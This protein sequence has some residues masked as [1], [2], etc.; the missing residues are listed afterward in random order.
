MGGWLSVDLLGIQLLRPP[1]PCHGPC[2]PGVRLSSCAT[3]AAPFLCGP[4]ARLEAL[5][6]A[7]AT[8]AAPPSSFSYSPCRGAAMA[9]SYPSSPLGASG[10]VTPRAAAAAGRTASVGTRGPMRASA[11]IT[12][13]LASPAASRYGKPPAMVPEWAAVPHPAELA[14]SLA[15]GAPA[16]PRRVA[17]CTHEERCSAG[18]NRGCNTLPGLEASVQAQRSEAAGFG[19]LRAK[20]PVKFRRGNAK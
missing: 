19:V 17:A 5:S 13:Q 11:V 16:L 3:H 9:P 8:A 6:C 12:Q 14:C 4:C 20:S 2:T 18:Q 1:P 7:A 15:L 10:G